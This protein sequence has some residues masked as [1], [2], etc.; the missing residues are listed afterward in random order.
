MATARSKAVK[1]APVEEKAEETGTETLQWF[2]T[3]PLLAPDQFKVADITYRLHTKLDPEQ[4]KSIRAAVRRIRTLGALVDK[5][6][7]VDYQTPD[8]V[9]AAVDRVEESEAAINDLF[10][11]VIGVLVEGFD[12]DSVPEG[13]KGLL[14]QQLM[15]R[16]EQFEVSVVF[17]E[18]G[19]SIPLA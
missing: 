5:I 18:L 17:A 15:S 10:D 12:C 16:Q 11:D 13:M 2:K 9:L 6:S 1:P 14:I 3:D 8:E 7:A 19:E 4:R